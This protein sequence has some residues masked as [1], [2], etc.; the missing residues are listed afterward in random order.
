MYAS[1]YTNLGDV[2]KFGRCDSE[3]KKILLNDKE[4]QRKKGKS[5][6]ARQETLKQ[7]KCMQY[8]LKYTVQ[9]LV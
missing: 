6:K 9:N 5:R 8:N 7:V 1:G 2:D 3:I 4:N